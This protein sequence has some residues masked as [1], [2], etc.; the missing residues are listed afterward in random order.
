MMRCPSTE[1]RRSIP[2]TAGQAGP[3]CKSLWRGGPKLITAVS[4]QRSGHPSPTIS[5]ASGGI[6]T[7]FE[8]I[9]FDRLTKKIILI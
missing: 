4:I 8:A 3:S 6:E 7:R 2:Q 9:S 5:A 1:A